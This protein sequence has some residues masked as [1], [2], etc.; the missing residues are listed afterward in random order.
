MDGDGGA[1][2]DG[3]VGGDVAGGRAASGAAAGGRAADGGRRGFGGWALPRSALR[4]RR[5][6][7]A[8]DAR[9]VPQPPRRPRRAP[10]R[11]CHPRPRVLRRLQPH[12][13]VTDRS[14]SRPGPPPSSLSYPKLAARAPVRIHIIGQFLCAA[15]VRVR[16]DP[17]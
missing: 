11:H 10:P 3:G 15:A 1:P 17:H 8:G 7:A 4:R 16:Q 9:R 2:V 13:K 6:P 5:T 12:A 14:V